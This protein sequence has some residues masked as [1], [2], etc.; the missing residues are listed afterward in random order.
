MQ[1]GPFLKD[2]MMKKWMLGALLA[3][4]TSAAFAGQLVQSAKIV[5]VRNTAG[6]NDVFEVV[7]G[8][9]AGPC[10]GKL[11]Q[12]P[13][14]AAGNAEIHERAFAMALTA[15]T[16]DATVR[17]HN[18]VDDTCSKASYITIRK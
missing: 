8:G 10:A 13:R 2:M 14:S 4:S 3:L 9:G 18:Y 7:L 17:I 11:V 1:C 6:N 5:E 12:F 15:L 16:T